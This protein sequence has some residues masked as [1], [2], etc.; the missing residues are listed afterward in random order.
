MPVSIQCI[1]PKLADNGILDA[2]IL[3]IMTVR[4]LTRTTDGAY[5]GSIFYRNG[6]FNYYESVCGLLKAKSDDVNMKF[7]SYI[8]ATVSKKYV[9]AGMETQKS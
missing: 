3:T 2:S 6:K 9:S 4:Y 7:L 5:A 8:L 1:H